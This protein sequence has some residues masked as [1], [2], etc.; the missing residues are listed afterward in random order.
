MRDSDEVV[1]FIDLFEGNME[2][3][4]VPNHLWA[5]MLTPLLSHQPLMAVQAL[6][7]D[8][9]QSYESVKE[10]A[11]GTCVDTYKRAG[12]SFFSIS[13]EKDESFQAYGR[14]L[15]RLCLRFSEADT[16]AQVQEKIT[17]QRFIHFLPASAAGFVR[18]RAPK[19]LTEATNLADE[20]FCNHG[21]SI[22]NYT[23]EHRLVAAGRKRQDKDDH[24]SFQHGKK[25][26]HKN[27]GG[28]HKKDHYEKNG[29]GPPVTEKEPMEESR[30]PVQSFRQK[31]NEQRPKNSSREIIC[32]KCNEKGHIS[33][34]CPLI[35]NL[36][37]NVDRNTPVHSSCIVPGTVAGT[38]AGKRVKKILVDSSA[39]VSVITE[40]FV[41]TDVETVGTTIVSGATGEQCQCRLVKIPV[42][43]KGRE[44]D[45][46]QRFCQ[47]VDSATQCFLGR[48]LLV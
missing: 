22:A 16:I 40:D 42:T 17:I 25:P 26:W 35:V 20:Y 5:Q 8:E 48:I 43:V 46:R 24:H 32:H 39:D 9:R 27:H 1:E 11:L 28:F 37:K 31:G 15:H 2:A 23:G 41:P 4:E 45:S 6:S 13:K 34:H 44:F 10:A 18:D 38:V 14:R 12:A 3:R 29:G 7:H 33:P 21:M 36:I 47:L 30:P 19:T